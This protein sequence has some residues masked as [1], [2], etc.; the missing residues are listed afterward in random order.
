M[1]IITS[2]ACSSRGVGGDN[3]HGLEGGDLSLEELD[4]L[5]G[6]FENGGGVH[7]SV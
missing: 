6:L 5:V 4:V 2:S 3:G 7:F 1:I